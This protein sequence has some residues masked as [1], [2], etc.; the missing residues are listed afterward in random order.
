VSQANYIIICK[1]R[2]RAGQAKS[3]AEKIIAASD[4]ATELVKH[5]DTMNPGKLSNADTNPISELQ[6]EMMDNVG[7][8]SKAEADA[9]VV[10]MFD[11]LDELEH[12]FEPHEY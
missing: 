8:W 5:I 6:H 4:C 9:A 3:A 7:K 12:K 10:E 11:L 1:G 2:I